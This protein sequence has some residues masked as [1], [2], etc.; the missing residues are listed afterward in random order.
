MKVRTG[1]VSNSSSSSFIIA[2]D[3]KP[4]TV[5][6]MIELLF[7]EGEERYHDPFSEDSW[8]VTE[9]ARIVF[10][11]I[12]GQTSMKERDIT[13][14]LTGGSIE[15]S[16]EMMSFSMSDHIW[17]DINLDAYRKATRKYEL[18]ISDE[19]RRQWD[20]KEI[21]NVEYEDG[22][23]RGSAMEHGNLFSNIEHYRVSC[24]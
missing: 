7:N 4:T 14:I 2:V 15:G 24:H 22:N 1:F 8:D 11:D 9:I 12:E 20:K 21:Y 18:E 5:E 23:S 10:K 13:E 19:I 16:P 17:G 3:K 6:E